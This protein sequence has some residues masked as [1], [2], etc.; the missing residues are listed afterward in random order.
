MELTKI[1][2]M[3][4]KIKVLRFTCYFGS[5]WIVM[6]HFGLFSFIIW[7]ILANSVF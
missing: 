2:I 7:T 5:L 6:A 3:S 1:V 4:Q